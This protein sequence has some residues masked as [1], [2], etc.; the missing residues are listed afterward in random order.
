ML[1]KNS[2]PKGNAIEKRPLIRP[3]F[4]T[5]QTLKHFA[6]QLTIIGLGKRENDW[7]GWSWSWFVV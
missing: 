5:K 4:K 7:G 1:E 6:L 3:S 2:N